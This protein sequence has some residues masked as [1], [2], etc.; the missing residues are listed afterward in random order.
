MIDD[1]VHIETFKVETN[2]DPFTVDVA[3]TN[4]KNVTV[5][6]E[7]EQTLLDALRSTGFDTPSSC[8]AGNCATCKV[9]V[10]CGK[11]VHVGQ[12]LSDEEKETQMLSCVS[13]G[14]GHIAISLPEA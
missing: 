1:E 8:E 14:V 9:T 2:G 7:A 6:V 3:S 4:S 10:R 11:V 5:K 12:A 13:R